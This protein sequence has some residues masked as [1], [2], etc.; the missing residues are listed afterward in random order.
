MLFYSQLSPALLLKKKGLLFPASFSHLSAQAF[1]WPHHELQQGNNESCCLLSWINLHS[2]LVHREAT[3]PFAVPE[4]KLAQG[5]N[6]K[7]EMEGRAGL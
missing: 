2:D 7:L 3:W 1:T 4:E 5:E 6:K